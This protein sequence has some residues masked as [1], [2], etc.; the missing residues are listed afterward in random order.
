VPALRADY[1]DQQIMTH[2][3]Y[4]SG[5]ISSHAN[6]PEKR[7]AEEA[8]N[9]QRFHAAASLMRERGLI[10]ACNPAELIADPGTTWEDYMRCCI[11]VL[12]NDCT[13]VVR[14]PGWYN[15]RGARLEVFIADNL[16]MEVLSLESVLRELEQAA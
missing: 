3:W 8:A 11:R 13:A 14:L 6:T 15:S 2:R 1:E 9:L 12:V 16:G 10:V 4:I 7:A 5:P